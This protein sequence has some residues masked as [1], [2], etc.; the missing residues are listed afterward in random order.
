MSNFKTLILLLTD[1]VRDL[2][3]D[4]GYHQEINSLVKFNEFKSTL[5]CD[6]GIGHIKKLNDINEHEISLNLT[7]QVMF[8]TIKECLAVFLA[9]L[10]KQKKLIINQLMQE[11]VDNILAVVQEQFNAE[12]VYPDFYDQFKGKDLRNNE[13]YSQIVKAVNN[14]SFAS[15]HLIIYSLMRV[16]VF[17]QEVT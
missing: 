8:T 6:I 9:D 2:P 1:M 7:P 4:L 5:D 13:D 3:R 16:K 10:E 11:K 12:R 14:S 17:Q 15:K